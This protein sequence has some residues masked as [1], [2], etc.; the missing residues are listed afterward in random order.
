MN[1]MTTA[2]NSIFFEQEDYDAAMKRSAALDE[3]IKASEKNINLKVKSYDIMNRGLEKLVEAAGGLE[4]D[5]NE[6]KV[7]E[8]PFCF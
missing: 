3:E 4:L 7:N 1:G 8:Q 6:I 5:P 2:F